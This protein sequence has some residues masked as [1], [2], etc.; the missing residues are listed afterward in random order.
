MW[1]T[2]GRFFFGRLRLTYWHPTMSK[3]IRHMVFW[4]E[5]LWFEHIVKVTP[6]CHRLWTPESSIELTAES[7][8]NWNH[9]A[10]VTNTKRRM[11]GL[12]LSEILGPSSTS[13]VWLGWK[14]SSD[15]IRCPHCSHQAVLQREWGEES[16]ETSR[17]GEGKLGVTVTTVHQPSQLFLQR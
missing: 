13:S 4:T 16:A 9:S 11:S 5:F 3:K 17:K 7:W 15:H 10:F 14:Q 8:V 12:F 2:S 6:V 1:T